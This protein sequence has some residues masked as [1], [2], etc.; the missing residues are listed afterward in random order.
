ME[1]IYLSLLQQI[2][3]IYLPDVLYVFLDR[4]ELCLFRMF[5]NFIMLFFP[6]MF[7]EAPVHNRTTIH[8]RRAYTYFRKVSLKR[9]TYFITQLEALL[10]VH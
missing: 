3:Y 9:N 2:T 4:T 1:T 6:S 5:L 7:L 10:I 8:C